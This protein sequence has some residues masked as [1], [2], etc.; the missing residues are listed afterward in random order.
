MTKITIPLLI[1]IIFQ[2]AYAKDIDGYKD[3]KFGMS[4]TEVGLLL[5]KQCKHKS[6][7]NKVAPNLWSASVF[8]GFNMLGTVGT[9]RTKGKKCYKLLG[10]PIP[11]I[12]VRLNSDKRVNLIII[13]L[14]DINSIINAIGGLFK[15]INKI[16]EFN[17]NSLL[18]GFNTK[19]DATSLLNTLRKKYKLTNQ[20]TEVVFN[21]TSGNFDKNHIYSFE[22]GKIF[23]IFTISEMSGMSVAFPLELIYQTQ[24]ISNKL[25]HKYNFKDK[26][27]SMDDI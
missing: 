21:T 1:F 10:K 19:N 13:T 26:T 2:N 11:E 5:D 3:L 6:K 24:E 25:L 22:N 7:I 20:K 17:T 4:E 27:V 14:S 12:E 23:L 8:N 15:D 18:S 16:D 9:Y